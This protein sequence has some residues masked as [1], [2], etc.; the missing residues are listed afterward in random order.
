MTTNKIEINELIVVDYNPS[1]LQDLVDLF[2][3]TV[4]VVAIKDYNQQQLDRWAPA[5]VDAAAWKQRLNNNLC[6]VALSNTTVVGFAEL[7]DDGHI[8]TM[9]VHKDHQRKGIAE[10]LLKE[11]L[12][13]AAIRNYE[14]LTTEASIT[15]KPF[16]EKNNFKVTQVKRKLYNGKEFINYKMVKEL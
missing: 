16:F 11:L 6:K 9:Y 7:T 5:N 2:Y 4:H 15:A 13:I 10:S 8:D 12:Q 14:V 3:E 1:M